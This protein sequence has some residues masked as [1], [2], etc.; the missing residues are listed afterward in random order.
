M[1]DLKAES[2]VVF[3]RRAVVSS[4]SGLSLAAILAD[5]ALAKKRA[6]LLQTIQLETKTKGKS[7]TGSLA[8][9]D[10]LSEKS[11]AILLVH[12]WY[13]LNDQIRSVAAEFAKEGYIAL[14]ADLYDRKIGFTREECSAL[15]AAVDAEEAEDTLVSWA[16][17]L[18]THEHSTGKI[19]VVGWCM[20]GS[21]SLRTSMATPMDATVVYYGDVTPKAD[22]L[23]SLSGPVLGHFAS[24]DGWI[25]PEM[26]EGFKDEMKAA[27]KPLKAHIY[28]A[29]HAFANPTKASYADGP[30]AKAW[31]RTLKFFA[32][33]LH[34]S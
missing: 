29:D 16:D 34:D 13:G 1:R 24:K 25:K 6:S 26:V 12:E 11:P 17:W 19:G 7:V 27:K 9:P 15:M 20:G 31:D 14:A 4:L 30:A 8:L 5:P 3:N 22:A 10:D 33:N 21:W 18:R 23:S 32:K 2:D 28:E